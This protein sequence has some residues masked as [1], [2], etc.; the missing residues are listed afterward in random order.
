[1]DDVKKADLNAWEILILIREIAIRLHNPSI[2]TMECR[3][4]IDRLY[5]LRLNL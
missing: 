4:I 3:R 1:M 5:E 2:S